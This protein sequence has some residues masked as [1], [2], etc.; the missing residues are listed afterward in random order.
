VK[1]HGF[2]WISGVAAATPLI[3]PKP[4]ILTD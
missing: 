1:I 2:G 4:C 3:Q